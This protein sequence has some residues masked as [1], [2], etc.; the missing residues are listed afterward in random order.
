MLRPA[1][2]WAGSPDTTENGHHHVAAPEAS[3]KVAPHL[4]REQKE[5]NADQE[6]AREGGGERGRVAGIAEGRAPERGNVQS[7]G[8]AEKERGVVREE[9]L[10]VG[11]EGDQ[12]AKAA[13]GGRALPALAKL[14]REK[15][16]QNLQKKLTFQRQP[17]KRKRMI[18]KM[19]K[20]RKRMLAILTRISSKRK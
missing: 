16:D 18:K 9:D 12:E 5:K 10:A 7:V 11:K 4:T 6:A 1:E 14:K 19:I 13:L 20:T 2:P 8:Q 17:R 3:P 15:K